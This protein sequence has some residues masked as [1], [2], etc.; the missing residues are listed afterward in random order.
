MTIS[1]FLTRNNYFCAIM[2]NRDFTE[3][4]SGLQ[5]KYAGSGLVNFVERIF[6]FDYRYNE[7]ND[8]EKEYEYQFI[9]GMRDDVDDLLKI[10]RTESVEYECLV[11]MKA[12]F[13]ERIIT[14]IKDIDIR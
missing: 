6:T 12:L 7:G 9:S 13:D 8:K 5:G 11:E 3:R 2:T 1:C 4:L 10:V 14:I